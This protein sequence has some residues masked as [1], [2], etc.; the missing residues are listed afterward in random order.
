[1][2]FLISLNI[3]LKTR[4]LFEDRDHPCSSQVELPLESKKLPKFSLLSACLKVEDAVNIL[5]TPL[6]AINFFK[7]KVFLKE[8]LEFRIKT[9]GSVRIK[10]VFPPKATFKGKETVF[11]RCII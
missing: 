5:A 8:I 6:A 7:I 2:L 4:Y 10:V 1:M 9:L 11:L 3:G